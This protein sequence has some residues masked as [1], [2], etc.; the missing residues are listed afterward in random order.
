MLKESKTIKVIKG[1]K[2]R[3]GL[4]GMRLSHVFEIPSISNEKPSTST[5]IPNIWFENLGFRSKY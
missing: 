1:S 2:N 5:E 3:R 4:Y